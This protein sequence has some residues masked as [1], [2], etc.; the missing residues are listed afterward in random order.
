MQTLLQKKAL[1]GATA[2]CSVS[3]KGVSVRAAAATTEKVLV[4]K[5]S[6][7]VSAATDGWLRLCPQRVP[8]GAARDPRNA[9]RNCRSLRRLRS[10]C[11]VA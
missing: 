9:H 1:A 3:R 5:R 11:L 10:C 8:R 4:T 7:E 6:E 2:R